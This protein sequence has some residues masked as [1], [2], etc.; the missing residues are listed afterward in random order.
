M[1]SATT[2]QA[3][4]AAGMNDHVAKPVDPASCTPRCCAGCPLLIEG[5]DTRVALKNLR[6]R[7]DTYRRVLQQFVDHYAALRPQL[8]R[9]PDADDAGWVRQAAHGLKGSASAIG[10]FPLATL[11]EQVE[12][13]GADSQALADLQ[14]GLSCVM[15]AIDQ[16]LVSDGA[17]AHA[18]L[19]ALSGHDRQQLLVLLEAGDFDAVAEARRLMPQLL[20]QHPTVAHQIESAMS[21]FD[22]ERALSALRT[23]T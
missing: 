9:L 20:Q 8:S 23:L 19:P 5:L 18:A 11:A 14:Q 21:V 16:H 12:T 6:G 15:Q 13:Q 1:P 2:A 4:L 22:F 10:A 17:A 3:C 7:R